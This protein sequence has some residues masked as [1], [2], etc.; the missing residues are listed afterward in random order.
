MKSGY[1]VSLLTYFLHSG[2]VCTDTRQLQSGQ[3]YFALRGER[4]DGNAFVP[5]ALQS[6]ALKVVTDDTQY[7]DSKD[8][9]ILFVPN[10]LIALQTL[11]REYRRFIDPAVIGVT[12]SNGKTTTKE[13]LAVVLQKKYQVWSTP[14]NWNNHIGVPLTLLSMPSDTQICICEMGA[15][16]LGEI[17]SYC[18]IAEPNVGIIT[19]IGTAHIGEFGGK[20]NILKA[21]TELFR[22][23]DQHGGLLFVNRDV[24]ELKEMIPD[25][26]RVISYGTGTNNPGGVRLG[27]KEGEA[28]ATIVWQIGAVKQD[29]VSQLFGEHNTDNMYSAFALGMHFDV[30]ANEIQD[31]ITEY[32]PSNMRS[33]IIQGKE[34]SVINDAY[35]ANPDSME[36]AILAFSN[37]Q[38]S[39]SKMCIL[40]GMKELGAW[41]EESHQ[42]LYQLTKRLLPGIDCY[43][44]GTEFSSCAIPI[45]RY[46]QDVQEAVS[47]FTKINMKGKYILIKGSRGT[48]LEKLVPVFIH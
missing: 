12:G 45:N 28:L 1:P 18:E 36:A 7:Q 46:F 24:P 40:G 32:V 35:N 48:Q 38:V 14:G 10:S 23:V 6:D 33:Q 26:Q 41:S 42:D 4:F 20:E 43:F 13:L 17:H 16:H 39:E 19:N 2:G 25:Y 22:W 29:C 30:P 15:N 31:A 47:Y 5:Q 11:A 27:K 34:N 21:K 8:E 9:R 3:I 44:V 37:M